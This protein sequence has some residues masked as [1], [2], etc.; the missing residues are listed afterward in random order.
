MIVVVIH[1]YLFTAQAFLNFKTHNTIIMLYKANNHYL[2]GSSLHN[3]Q[4]VLFNVGLPVDLITL[5]HMSYFLQT[6]VKQQ[7]V[8]T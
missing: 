4:D 6:C 7:Y 1:V 3:I 2:E 8:K 5:A